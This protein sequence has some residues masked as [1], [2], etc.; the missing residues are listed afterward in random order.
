MVRHLAGRCKPSRRGTV[1]DGRSCSRSP[2]HARPWRRNRLSSECRVY[3][4]RTAHHRVPNNPY[5]LVVALDSEVARRVRAP[6]SQTVTVGDGRGRVRRTQS[7]NCECLARVHNGTCSC[8]P[9]GRS[10]PSSPSSQSRYTSSQGPF[11]SRLLMGVP[12][13]QPE[14]KM[15]ESVPQDRAIRASVVRSAE[16]R[17]RGSPCCGN[18]VIE[19][20]TQGSGLHRRRHTPTATLGG[21]DVKARATVRHRVRLAQCGS[22]AG[23]GR[24]RP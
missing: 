7:R 24:R 4:R 17:R 22:A 19:L 10:A 21:R 23:R 6:S 12:S 5:R 2:Q 11:P 13:K 3:R 18:T 1:V 20:S 14:P 9:C 16:G 15:S 8:L